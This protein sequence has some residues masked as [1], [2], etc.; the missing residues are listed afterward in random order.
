MPGARGKL[1][2]VAGIEVGGYTDDVGSNEMNQK[3]SEN[4]AGAVRDYL[5]AA[6][7]ANNTVTSKGLG[8]SMPVDSNDNS[9][10][11][12]AN[13]KV[14]LVVSGQAIGGPINTT[15]GSLR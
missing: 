9:A 12:L 15:T 2:K 14:E 1:G 4:R 13:R 11:R 5:V 8:N 6:G 7:V 10:G 3:L